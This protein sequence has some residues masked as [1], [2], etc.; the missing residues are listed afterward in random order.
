[1][2]HLHT[3]PKP[4]HIILGMRLQDPLPEWITHLA[5][6]HK[7]GLVQTGKKQHVLAANAS[8][9]GHHLLLVFKELVKAYGRD[10]KVKSYQR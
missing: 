4:P 3:S 7:D 10:S 5:L 8:V 1:M 9:F 2:E 6:V